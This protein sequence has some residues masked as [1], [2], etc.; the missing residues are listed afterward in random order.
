MFKLILLAPVLTTHLIAGEVLTLDLPAAVSHAL[1]HIPA[2]SSAKKQKEIAEIV[3][4]TAR[5]SFF[6]KLN[7]SALS[8]INATEP[9]W[10]T[11]WNNS[12]SFTLQQPILSHLVNG[13]DREIAH[14]KDAIAQLDL[15][16]ERD[17]VCMKVVKDFYAYS[18][19]VEQL[20]I[21]KQKLDVLLKQLDVVNRR[22][23]Q[24]FKTQRD[25]LRFEAQVQQAQ[26][27]LATA[28]NRVLQ[29]AETLITTITGVNRQQITE[30][31]NFIPIKPLPVA[32]VSTPKDEPKIEKHALYK[33][34]E[35]ELKV[36]SLN[37]DL[38][39]RQLWPE[40]SATA[41]AT[42][43]INVGLIRAPLL[44][45]SSL[46]MIGI[47][48][49]YE[50]FDFG[51]RRRDI[52]IAMKNE[53]IKA[54]SI[55][56]KLSNETAAI[57]QMMVSFSLLQENISLN[58]KLL[59]LEEDNFKRIQSDYLQGKAQYLDVISALNNLS[60]VKSALISSIFD[61]E[62]QLITYRYYEGTLYDWIF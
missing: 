41:S 6:P 43:N 22:F 11:L 10:P 29:G 15:E 61:F 8:G 24:G 19:A 31:F 40:L 30:S 12:L 51:K 23:Q 37:V 9:H 25:V 55:Q 53:E 33:K 17:L 21:K 36:S 62:T 38:S 34:L 20:D 46:F 44:E 2:L 27:Q 14:T 48:L 45:Q 16:I 26:I 60:D 7:L 32:L 57:A 13:V 47:S 5:F 39:R 54:H 59:A 58:K 52:S 50:L 1:K 35:L 3:L 28:K 56:T 49:Q 18:A 42:G 4:K